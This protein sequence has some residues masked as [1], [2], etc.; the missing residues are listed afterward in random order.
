MMGA[1]HGAVDDLGRRYQPT[2]VQGLQD[3]F[4]QPRQDPAAELAVG[5]GPLGKYLRQITLRRFR[6]GD[7]ENSIKNKTMFH[8]FSTIQGRNSKN[9]PL[10]KASLLVRYQILC[11]FRLHCRYQLES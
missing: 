8:R 3:V 6:A 5:A 11:Q 7:P 1:D 4:P 10:E 2:F 9:K